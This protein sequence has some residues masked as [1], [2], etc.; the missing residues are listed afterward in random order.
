MNI[1]ELVLSDNKL[2]SKRAIEVAQGMAN[3]KKLHTSSNNITDEAV[4][5]LQNWIPTMHHCP[6][7]S[8]YV[9]WFL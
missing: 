3:C 9:T 8:L 5:L 2:G 4:F 7:G 1:T 6:S